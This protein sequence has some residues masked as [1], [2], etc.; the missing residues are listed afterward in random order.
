MD[1]SDGAREAD[2][3]PGAF[4][5]RARKIRL[6][7]GAAMLF[8]DA[9][10][11]GVGLAGNRLKTLR[12]LICAFL[13]AVALAGSGW[14]AAE[15]KPRDTLE[16]VKSALAEI[17]DELKLDN[18]SDSQ[19]AQL[20]ARAEPLAGQLQSVIADLAPRLD[21][22]HKR[23]TELTP[24]SKEVAREP[25]P[26]ADELKAEQTKYDALDA[27]LR[28]AR[29]A[30][31]QVE[32]YITRIGNQR[33]EIFTKQTFARSSSVLS[34]VLWL[35]VVR[36]LPGDIASF[37]RLLS[38]VAA[39]LD[40]HVTPLQW[41]AFLGICAAILIFAAPLRRIAHRVIAPAQEAKA[42]GRLRK[43]LVGVWTLIVLSAGPLAALGVI[44]YSLDVFDISDP[45]LEGVVGAL[46]DGLRMTALAYACAEAL[47]APK[48]ETWRLLP[49]GN[50]SAKR[51]TR[52][53]IGVAIILSA[54]RLVEAIAESVSSY[55]LL[56][57]TRALCALAISGFAADNLRKLGR[58]PEPGVQARDGWAPART[59][60]WAY[61]VAVFVCA[62]AGYIALATFLIEHALQIGGVIAALYLADALIQES[63]EGLLRPESSIAQ[64][65]KATLGLGR[66]GLEQIVVLVQGLA[67]LAV[68]I[69]A[70][71]AAIGPFGM[72]SQDLLATLRTVYFGFSVGGVTLS[73]STMMAAI[74]L[75][76]LILA[77][78]RAGQTWLGERYLPR[79][80]LDAG[81][82]N[83]IR[84]IF[85]YLGVVLAL[86]FSGSRLGVDAER[87]AWVAG[88]LSVGIGFGLQGI[89]N[90]FISGLILL[91]ERGIRVGDW[92]VIGQDQGFVRRINA[93]STEIET[94]ERATLIVPNLTL[95]TGSV[96]NWMHTDRVARIVINVQA[97]FESDP[98]VVRQLLIDA[99]KA[100]DAV[101]SIPAPLALFVEFG[102]WAMKFQLIVYVEEALMAERVRSELNFDIMQRMRAAS[103][104]I[105]YPFPVGNV[106]TERGPNVSR[107]A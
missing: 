100:Q 23:L 45:Q 7:L 41:S 103:L 79:T 73:I 49:I 93:R 72:P 27:D 75:F 55:N 30:L 76:F 88:G 96:K 65:L 19:L 31:L 25:D 9:V 32:D 54:S 104:R 74:V 3:L 14:G 52:L 6:R 90:N 71:V 78:T 34:P 48:M 83:S 40:D 81:V 13:L 95:V 86:L 12:L 2:A 5:G 87:V 62:L 17:D 92:V 22:S 61:V 60:A 37:G 44:S 63:C 98:E 16:T 84:T 91:W 99:A 46:L 67:R 80:N 36:E 39:R 106:E 107:I 94:F 42:P 28:S 70:L 11:E 58:T 8:G 24:K 1:A 105:P 85:G 10:R 57:L 53:A 69:G 56:V 68:I 51:I 15:D 59:F 20:R 21:A 38:N 43:A 33:R 77:A 29:A 50:S 64:T 47:L 66:E 101:L 4:R 18:L 97:A 26:A 82:K 89:A 35:S 102:D